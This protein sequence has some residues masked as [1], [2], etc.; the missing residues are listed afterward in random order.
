[1][2]DPLRWLDENMKRINLWAQI[3]KPAV[4]EEEAE[5]EAEENGEVSS[6]SC[7]FLFIT[8]RLHCMNQISGYGVITGPIRKGFFIFL[9]RLT[10]QSP[11]PPPPP[12]PSL[13]PISSW[14]V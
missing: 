11:P 6:A 7:V 12:P 10:W 13:P 4:E 9:A 5:E 1:M 14:C 3:Y 8:S 2:D